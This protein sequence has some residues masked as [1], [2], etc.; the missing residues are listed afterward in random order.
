MLL[1]IVSASSGLILSAL[2]TAA[3]VIL[4]FSLARKYITL[5]QSGEV[6]T[7]SKLFIPGTAA[8]LLIEGER[9]GV[10]GS[11]A[12]G[13]LTTCGLTEPTLGFELRLDLL[14]KP[15]DIDCPI[16]RPSDF[17]SVQ[18]DINLVV[19]E[20]LAWSEIETVIRCEA[21]PHF[22]SLCVRQVWRD[23][24]RLGEG[25]KSILVGLVMRSRTGT[26]SSDEVRETIDRI[27]S[28]CVTR[29]GAS[30]RA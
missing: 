23:A 18:R 3:V 28:C 6:N 4:G 17:P 21:G 10:I 8:E 5:R 9:V 20:R 1:S 7:S 24:Q 26:L 30:L 14:E 22:E 25:K 27:V 11:I 13:V 19:D 12:K 29:C 15:M 2:A 16:T